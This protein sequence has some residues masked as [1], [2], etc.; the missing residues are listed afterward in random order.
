MTGSRLIVYTV[1]LLALGALPPLESAAQLRLGFEAGLANMSLQRG[2]THYRGATLTTAP[3]LRYSLGATSVSGGV[4]SYVQMGTPDTD[5]E[6]GFEDR[7]FPEYQ[8][9]IQVSRL[10]NVVE[11]STGVVRR[12]VGTGFASGPAAAAVNTWEIYLQAHTKRSILNAGAAAFWDVDAARGAF[13]RP[14]I[15][16]RI[17]GLNHAPA[18]VGRAD[19][20]IGSLLAIV[21]AGFA[22]DQRFDPD[23]GRFGYYVD[24]GLTHVDTRLVLPVGIEVWT[25]SAMLN[26]YWGVQFNRDLRTRIVG[27]VE[28]EHER[29][30]KVVYGLTLSVE[31][32]RCRPTLD[33][34]R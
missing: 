31:V 29:D 9:W 16:L 7:A 3:Y 15:S 26:L 6:I 24:N 20:L 25:V 5:R 33:L 21:S 19:V 27:L 32:P 1:V 17:P 13:V 34:C 23:G 11:I 12:V 14:E 22:I 28:K 2:L 18:H 10:L 4:W 30:R 8:G